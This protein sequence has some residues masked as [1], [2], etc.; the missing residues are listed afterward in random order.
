VA[1]VLLIAWSVAIG[2]AA[3]GL[4]GAGAFNPDDGFLFESERWWQVFGIAAYLGFAGF[5]LIPVVALGRFLLL[6]A[7]RIA[8]A[9]CRGESGAGA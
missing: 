9:R 1:R 5:Y 8:R 3:V 2:L 6:T 7:R 4:L